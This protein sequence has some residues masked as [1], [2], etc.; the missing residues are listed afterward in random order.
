MI[1]KGSQ[2]AGARNLSHH[3]LNIQD[4]DH[5]TVLELSGFVSDDLHGALSEIHAISKA[6][7]CTQFMFSLSLNPPQDFCAGEQEFIDAA[8]RVAEKLGLDGQPRA[9]VIHE[10]NGRRHAHVVWSRIANSAEGGNL[11]AINLPHFKRK[12]N[13]LSRDLYLDHGWDLP[14][15][16]Q[17]NGGK[18]PLNFTLAE[19]QQ[20]KRQ[21]LDPREI[22]NVFQEAWKQA[23]TLK[24]FGNAMA[25]RGYFIARGDRRGFVALDVN[26]DVYSLPKWI[27]VRTKEIKIRFGKPDHLP[28]VTDAQRAVRARLTTRVKSF[29][30]ETKAKHARDCEPLNRDK[31]KLVASH[32][33]ER[34]RLTQNQ[35]NRWKSETKSRADRLRTGMRGLLDKITGRA[36]AIRQANESQAYAG[37]VRDRNQRDDLTTG[38]MAD[39]QVLQR[40]FDALSKKHM[41]DRRILAREI[42][43]ILRMNERNHDIDAPKLKHDQEIVRNRSRERRSGPEFTL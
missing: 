35:E 28:S 17:V 31:S 26:G 4:N 27:G 6:T 42:T 10:K 19:W 24:A 12:L 3:L 13:D 30:A 40:R 43:G 7:Q 15:G 29:I 9:I 38:Q 1:L 25:E 16:L 22:K 23:D 21:G 2:R 34:K 8:D 5:V 36:K 20:A 11:K 37:I 18:S 39:R 33:A 41:N 14:K 32:R